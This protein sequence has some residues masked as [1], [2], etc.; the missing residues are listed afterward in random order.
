MEKVLPGAQREG[1]QGQHPG[2]QVAGRAQ[3]EAST[4]AFP[5]DPSHSWQGQGAG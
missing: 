3:P 2:L 1:N 4:E 5:P